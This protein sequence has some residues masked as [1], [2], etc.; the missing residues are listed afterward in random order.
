MDRQDVER[1][2][3]QMLLLRSRNVRFSMSEVR[4]WASRWIG[5]SARYV[6]YLPPSVSGAN[7]INSLVKKVFNLQNKT[8][9]RNKC[10]G[11][12]G[13]SAL[14][15]EDCSHSTTGFDPS[16]ALLRVASGTSALKAGASF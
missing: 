5:E 9:M 6:F 14:K 11:N 16:F 13:I 10:L 15:A 7:F 3:W 1:A 8:L 2:T 12:S 4:I